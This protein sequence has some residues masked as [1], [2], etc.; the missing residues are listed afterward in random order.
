MQH[1]PQLY[2]VQWMT[3]PSPAVNFDTFEVLEEC[4]CPV[5]GF[6]GLGQ[7]AGIVLGC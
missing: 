4:S 1:S 7:C 2:N 5:G 3:A 6:G